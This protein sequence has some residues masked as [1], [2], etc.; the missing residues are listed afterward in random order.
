MLENEDKR[1]K[2]IHFLNC[3]RRSRKRTGSSSTRRIT[4]SWVLHCADGI[5]TFIYLTPFQFFLFRERLSLKCGLTVNPEISNPPK[6]LPCWRG[7][8]SSLLVY[9]LK[10]S[11]TNLSIT[12]SIR[13]EAVSTTWT[14]TMRDTRHCAS[15]VSRVIENIRKKILHSGLPQVRWWLHSHPW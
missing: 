9:S 1:F 2:V 7:E 11:T 15:S 3:R 12:V 8:Y 6:L 10:L 4:R 5:L 13:I 14:P